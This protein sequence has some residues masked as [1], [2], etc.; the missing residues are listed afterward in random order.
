MER[1]ARERS[2]KKHAK[3]A[4]PVNTGVSA[5]IVPRAWRADRA[6]CTE[7]GAASCTLQSRVSCGGAIHEAFC[8][9]R[10]GR[11][12]SIQLDPSAHTGA[13]MRTQ[14]AHGY[15]HPDAARERASAHARNIEWF[16]IVP[17]P[18]SL[19][20]PPPVSRGARSAGHVHAKGRIAAHWPCRTHALAAAVQ[21]G[22]R[23][24][25]DPR[26]TMPAQSIEIPREKISVQFGRDGSA[27][28]TLLVS[29]SST[30]VFWPIDKPAESGS[31]TTGLSAL[32]TRTQ[33][34]S[35]PVPSE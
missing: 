29:S 4:K 33:S 31:T 9:R 13:V 16:C 2:I 6:A 22:C 19:P 28:G 8:T 30:R 25:I 14:R 12:D 11:V 7:R 24:R 35:S 10:R 15:A 23:R 1:W 5:Q 26:S 17:T 27:A 34:A 20:R 18:R 21:C 32:G 3:P